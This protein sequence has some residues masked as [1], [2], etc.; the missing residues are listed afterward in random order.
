MSG[1]SSA[2]IP[3]FPSASPF[4]SRIRQMWVRLPTAFRSKRT[5]VIVTGLPL[6]TYAYLHSSTSFHQRVDAFLAPYHSTLFRYHYS[7]PKRLLLSSL[8]GDTLDLS[9]SDGSTLSC[10]PSDVIYSAVEPN[11]FV[12]SSFASNA[13][14]AGYP[15]GTVALANTSPLTALRSLPNNSK[16]AVVACEVLSRRGGSG[17][18]EEEG[19]EAVMAEVHR[20]LKPGG[21][22]YFVDFT[23]RNDSQ[24]W[25]RTL[26]T[27][28]SPLTRILMN[29][30]TLD[31]PVVQR[32]G[33]NSLG[34]EKVYLET[35]GSGEQSRRVEVVGNSEGGKWEGEGEETRVG[36]EVE[37]TGLEGLMP[38][39]GGICVKRKA[40]HLAQYVN[41]SNTPLL[42]E[43]FQY[44]TIRTRTPQQDTATTGSG[45]RDPVR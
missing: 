32:I 44:G 1:P 40:A 7:H 22:F 39:V 29:G 30:V 11:P 45:Q 3:N 38:V 21:R 15:P 33:R 34:W 4:A 31:T 20:V 9:P 14:A 28:M 16:D 36:G 6:L 41:E 5:A 18:G 24:R 42:E 23:A 26:Q 35:W 43:L 12:L 13:A 10:L 27:L 17:D 25:L 37:V 8:R 2:V 19:M